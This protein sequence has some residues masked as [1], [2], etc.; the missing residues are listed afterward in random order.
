MKS[1][2]HEWTRQRSLAV[3][4][5]LFV[6]GFLSQLIAT[7]QGGNPSGVIEDGE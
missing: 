6:V 4:A 7:F 3:W 5:M 2:V 1:A